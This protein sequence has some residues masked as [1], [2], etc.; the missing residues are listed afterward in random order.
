MTIFLTNKVHT[1]VVIEKCENPPATP[2][3]VTSQTPYARENATF[4]TLCRNADQWEIVRSIKRMEDRFNRQFHYDWVFLNEE[5]FTEDF[6]RATSA[7]VSGEAKY[8]LIPK[9]HWSYPD[10]IDLEKAAKGREDMA[11]KGVIYAGLESYRHMCRFNSGFFYKHPLMLPYKYYWRVEPDVRIYCD[12][13]RDLFKFMRENNKTYGYTISIY[14]FEVTIATLWDRTKEYLNAHPGYLAENN[15]AEFLSE[16][17]LETY[18][19]CHFWSNFEIADMDFWRSE[20]YEG[21]FQHLDKAGGFFYERWGDA[22]VHSIAAALF[23]PRDKVHLFDD[24]GY[25]HG[26]YHVCPLDPKVRQ[27]NKCYCDPNDDFTFRGY[28]CGTRYYDV[29]KKPKPSNWQLYT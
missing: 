18:N 24:I 15:L 20:A 3:E 13:E 7:L 29:M 14:E 8:G 1:P 10:F 2:V 26:V 21:Y 28:S 11:V 27:A 23:L 25:N 4:V 5:P 6:V 17:N 9:E 12:V 16:D 22:P 19:L